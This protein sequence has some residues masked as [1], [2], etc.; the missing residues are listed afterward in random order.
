MSNSSSNS[1]DGW[2]DRPAPNIASTGSERVADLRDQ[3]SEQTDEKF[4]AQ[5]MTPEQQ[6]RLK[7]NRPNGTT[8]EQTNNDSNSRAPI[9]AGLFKT[10]QA[11]NHARTW[12][13]DSDNNSNKQRPTQ[14]AQEEKQQRRDINKLLPSLTKYTTIPTRPEQQQQPRAR[15]PSADDDAVTSRLQALNVLRTPSAKQ[16]RRDLGPLFAEEQNVAPADSRFLQRLR[17]GI[18]PIARSFDETLV[19]EV[20]L[21]Q[22]FFRS[23]KRRYESARFDTDSESNALGGKKHKLVCGMMDGWRAMYQLDDSELQELQRVHLKFGFHHLQ[24]ITD[25]HIE[26]RANFASATIA[27]KQFTYCNKNLSQRLITDRLIFI[28]FLKGKQRSQLDD[29]MLK[30]LAINIFTNEQQWQGYINLLLERTSELILVSNPIPRWKAYHGHD[31]D[32]VKRVGKT[33]IPVAVY[34]TYDR[35]KSWG[36]TVLALLKQLFPEVLCNGIM[37]F[38]SID[39]KWLAPE[40]VRVSDERYMLFRKTEIAAYD[41]MLTIMPPTNIHSSTNDDVCRDLKMYPTDHIY[42][43]LQFDPQLDSDKVYTTAYQHTLDR[44]MTIRTL[45]LSNKVGWMNPKLQR[46]MNQLIL[47]DYLWT[48]GKVVK[49]QQSDLAKVGIFEAAALTYEVTVREPHLKEV[50]PFGSLRL[51]YHRTRGAN[52]TRFTA[53]YVRGTGELGRGLLFFEEVLKKNFQ[54]EYAKICGQLK[55]RR[56]QILGGMGAILYKECLTCKGATGWSFAEQR[57]HQ[58]VPVAGRALM[59]VLP[60]VSQCISR[61]SEKTVIALI[62]KYTVSNLS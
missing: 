6:R 39:A 19:D 31:I 18:N 2:G 61:V 36:G 15:R 24:A 25:D 28:R 13:D 23:M 43:W 22:N 27:Q 4:E 11:N 57:R 34:S 20:A 40:L 29:L 33:R 9:P 26:A 14:Q 30:Y 38:F 7:R 35:S 41:Q 62:V 17:D 56:A 42:F 37:Q 8:P 58:H 1:A 51:S 54:T 10:P 52:L 12:R 32:G 60:H 59:N 47:N 53:T 44:Y 50:N 55:D 48:D 5:T 3:L 45:S 21:A 16:S 49:K 46:D